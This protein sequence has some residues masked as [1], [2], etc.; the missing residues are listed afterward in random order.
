MCLL[1]VEPIETV[2]AALCS[3]H[4]EMVECEIASSELQLIEDLELM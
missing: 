1:L 3:S 4:V 2:I